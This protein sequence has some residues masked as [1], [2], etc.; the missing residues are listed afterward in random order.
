[1]LQ[2]RITV[3]SFGREFEALRCLNSVNR[4][5]RAILEAKTVDASRMTVP[6]V[7]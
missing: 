3:S 1:V 4:H 6:L 2:L 5:P 7:N